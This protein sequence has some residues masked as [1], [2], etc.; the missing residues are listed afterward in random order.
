MRHVLADQFDL[1]A[2]IGGYSRKWGILVDSGAYKVYRGSGDPERVTPQYYADEFR[3]KLQQWIKQGYKIQRI[4]KK[5]S[6]RSS[7]RN[8]SSPESRE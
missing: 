2:T 3:Q 7:R 5:L 6:N 4:L 1:E 8:R